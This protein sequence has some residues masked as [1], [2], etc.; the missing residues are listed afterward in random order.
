MIVQI[1]TNHVMS[2]PIFGIKAFT[3]ETPPPL[4][5]FMWPDPLPD[6]K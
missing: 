3:T 6:A 2:N 1:G 5:S 4:L